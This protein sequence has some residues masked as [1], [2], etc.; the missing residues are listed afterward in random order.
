MATEQHEQFG[1]DFWRQRAEQLQTALD[2]RIVIEQAK[3]ML[4]E[5][6]G[7]G[8]EGSFGLLRHAARRNRLKLHVLA[9]AVVVDPETPEPI[10]Q[11]LA[12]NAETFM[13]VPRD[14]RVVRTE[15]LYKRLNEAIA[16]L[17]DGSGPGFLCECGNPLCNETMELSLEDLHLLHSR[18]GYYAIIPGHDIP[19][20]ETVVM[21]KDGYAVVQKANARMH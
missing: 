10:V 3:G 13:A 18:A 8:L 1:V 5:R 4:A 7:L 21:E 11:T 17:L 2:S 16:A 12:L 6:F 15:E 9:R 14:E 19:D 20:L